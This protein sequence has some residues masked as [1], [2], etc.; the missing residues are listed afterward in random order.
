M[1]MELYS[2]LVI[3]VL[4][5]ALSGKISTLKINGEFPKQFLFPCS[6]E[7][8][9]VSLKKVSLK[10]AFNYLNLVSFIIWLTQLNAL[11]ELSLHHAPQRRSFLSSLRLLNF[12]FP[13]SQLR[14][15][16]LNGFVL[17][18]FVSEKLKDWPHLEDLSLLC[19]TY[20][21]QNVE[22][23]F[24]TQLR[25]LEVSFN[26]VHQLTD[27]ISHPGCQLKIV[28]AQWIWGQDPSPSPSEIQNV[29]DAMRKNRTIEAF[30]LCDSSLQQSV[31]PYVKRNLIF[32]QLMST[33]VNIPA[34]LWPHLLELVAGSSSSWSCG[35]DAFYFV[36]REGGLLSIEH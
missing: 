32:N 9:S 16:S 22:F 5:Q 13:S 35:I 24:L 15:L 28:D 2:P 18:S 30:H 10:T 23:D 14:K 6:F 33:S 29:I 7:K 26:Q 4:A 25:R 8:L 3:C 36:F 19:C 17:H 20:L 27:L 1:D 31:S 11:E 12:Y 21:E 34:G